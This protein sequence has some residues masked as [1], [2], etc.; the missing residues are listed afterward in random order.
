M[1]YNL[2]ITG[3]EYGE[4]ILE[5]YTTNNRINYTKYGKLLS[6]VTKLETIN[7]IIKSKYL[8]Y[9][10][11][12]F[13][14]KLSVKPDLH[15]NEKIIRNTL[16][17]CPECYALIHAVIYERD[18]EVWIKKVCPDHGK[19]DDLYWS[20]YNFYMRSS[21]QAMDGRGID[22]PNIDVINACPYN[23]G[24]C[25]RH[26]SHTALL[27]LA[28]T[29]RC[30]MACWY[31]FFFAERAGYIYEPPIEHIKY[32]LSVA[33][34]MR[35]IPAL[36]VQITGGEPTLREDVVEI[37]K[38]AKEL[39]YQH[40]QI[41]TTGVRMA[42]DPE[43]PKRFR[44]VGVNTFYVSFDGV[45]PHTN[46]K[47]HWE[48]PY[49]LENCYNAQVGVVLVPTVLKTVNDH[50]VGKIVLFG[51]KHNHVVRGVNFQPVSLV[52]RMNKQERQKYRIT[53]PDIIRR[54][55][56]QTDGMICANDWYTVPFTIPLS[57]F[58]EAVTR[59]RKLELT[60]H[61]AC[62]VATYVFQ[63]IKSKVITPVTRFIDVEGL[64]ELLKEKAEEISNGKNRKIALI[65]VL[66]KLNK[67]IDWKKVP[68]RLA[69]RRRL[70]WILYKILVK[71]DYK[72]L[73]EFHY[74]SL[75]IG[76]MHFMDP[77]NYDIN[78]I[79]RCDIHYVT[80]DGR[81]IPFCTYN[82]MP[83]LYRDRM[84]RL[85]SIP[86]SEYL[87]VRKIDSLARERYKRNIKKLESGEIYK[88]YYE[89]FF[90]PSLLPY[91]E[92]RKISLSFGIPVID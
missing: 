15:D 91:E 5:E 21:R 47:N 12:D 24:L 72:A 44:E 63:D 8:P 84:N 80:P 50:E 4:K 38:I 13:K 56:E 77:Y 64:F 67:Y 9:K 87:R 90:D 73:G 66:L 22:N 29:N 68:P 35:P 43:L 40:V 62:G 17:I 2:T 83:K 3:E 58:I 75:F 14:V 74:N 60:N 55:E 33:R 54:I 25:M 1:L 49:T 30:D 70:Y 79:Q 19:V 51:L 16:S 92:K 81:I 65:Q 48:I 36:A 86:I 39:G 27:N 7:S 28:V 53:I 31:C 85:Y 42:F 88:K 10:D 76:M 59:Q 11:V 52:G 37:A 78:R 46:P 6:D 41:N 69:K 82:V 71:H 89:G 32:M 45:T 34:Q 18:G 57:R 23:C 61:F 20:D 26:K